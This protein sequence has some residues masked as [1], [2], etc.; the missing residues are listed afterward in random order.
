MVLIQKAI[1]AAKVIE[2]EEITH[3]SYETQT[4]LR[5]ELTPIKVG[6]LDV[7]CG[8]WVLSRA[9]LANVLLKEFE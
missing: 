1:G 7:F 3:K 2:M 6:A 5:N 9:V 8:N 4:H